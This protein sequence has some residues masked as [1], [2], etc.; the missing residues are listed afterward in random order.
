VRGTERVILKKPSYTRK[1]N[2]EEGKR[3]QRQRGAENGLNIGKKTLRRMAHICYA[4]GNK[5]VKAARLNLIT[6]PDIKES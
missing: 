1:E 6:I 5:N 2:L 3:L 4:K